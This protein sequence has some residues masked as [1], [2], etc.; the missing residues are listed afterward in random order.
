MT[1]FLVAMLLWLVPTELSLKFS[2]ENKFRL[3][4]IIF[5]ITTIL[6][7]ISI[8]LMKLTKGISSILMQER[9]DRVIPFF[10]VAIYYA[11]AAYLLTAR[12]SLGGLFD[13]VM[14]TITSVVILSAIITVFWKISVHSMGVAGVLGVLMGMNAHAPD[15][16]FYWPIMLWAVILGGTMSA[17]I[18]LNAHRPTEVW[19]GAVVGFVVC[20]TSMII[21]L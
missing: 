8:I 10:L 9:E 6:P 18:F 2:S 5:L 4:L 17:R 12:V 11:V 14:L 21:F 19:V 3:L 7:L 13:L 20:F 1:S 15:V 16:K